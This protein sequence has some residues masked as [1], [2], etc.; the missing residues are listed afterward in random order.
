MSFTTGIDAWMLVYIILIVFVAYT[1]K[2]FAGF[3]SGLI[4]VPLLALVLPLTII[5]PALGLISYSGTILQSI[6]LRKS[7]VW[8]DCLVVLPFTI[9]GVA[10]GLYLFTSL[11]LKHLNQLLGVFVTGYAIFTLFPAKKAQLG[12]VW[13][14]VAGYAG[15]LVGTIFGTG[16]PFYVIYLKARQHGKTAFRANIAMIFLM[17]GAMRIIGYAYSG[18]YSRESLIL[19]LVSLPLLLLGLYTGHHIHHKV[20]QLWFNRVI[21]LILIVAG[22]TLLSK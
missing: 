20:N 7:V 11:D 21:S 17:D 22:I 8:A 2:G 15:G 14:A 16:G 10:S 1:I 13:G 5:V 6:Q 4:A 3:G 18:F 12:R 9:L 19:A